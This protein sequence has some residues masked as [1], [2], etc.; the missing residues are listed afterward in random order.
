MNGFDPGRGQGH[1][2]A[3]SPPALTQRDWFYGAKRLPLATPAHPRDLRQPRRASQGLRAVGL[4]NRY[5]IL[6]AE[7]RPRAAGRGGRRRHG[8]GT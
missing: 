3:A 1:R 8:L 5:E 7:A 4:W 2:S 6:G